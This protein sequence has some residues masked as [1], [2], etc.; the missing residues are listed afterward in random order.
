M[1]NTEYSTETDLSPEAVWAALRDLHSGTRL[2]DRS[3]A[4]ELHGPFAV[5]TAISVTPQGQGTFRSTITELA[6]NEVYADQTTF[7][8]LTL[9]FRH[10]LTARPG[11]GGTTVTHRLEIGGPGSAQQAPEL[12]P[13][14]SEDFP[15]A[16]ADLL[17][18]ARERSTPA[19]EHST[20][21][22]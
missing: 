2:S 12:G 1:W 15:V 8:D 5:G 22:R 3:D 10:T 7:G 4:F 16:M 20:P 14:I 6:E 11:G 13:Q 18:A 17:A 19:P 9:L 21:A